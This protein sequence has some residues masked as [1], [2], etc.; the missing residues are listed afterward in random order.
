MDNNF[1]IGCDS[2]EGVLP[3]CTVAKITTMI[4]LDAFLNDNF[5]PN[6]RYPI[7][8]NNAQKIANGKLVVSD[9]CD[10]CRLCYIACPKTEKNH[11][12]LIGINDEDIL[13][14]T[15]MTNIVVKYLLGVSVASEIKAKGNARQKRLDLVIK[16][17]E[18]VYII[19]ILRSVVRT[20]FYHRSYEEAICE[21]VKYYPNLKFNI[22]FLT[23]DRIYNEFEG[24]SDF[25][26]CTLHNIKEKVMEA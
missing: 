18:N 10:S 24:T 17:N 2:L 4:S 25:K 16:V 14:D 26:F 22:L 20:S 13:K 6:T 1:C 11:L 3:E 9:K 12:D 8:H 23:T 15:N 19:K 5:S 21:Y 7:C